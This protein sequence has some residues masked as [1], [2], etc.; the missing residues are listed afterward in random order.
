MQSENTSFTVRALSKK[1]LQ[2]A[3]NVSV[4]TLRSW[5]RTV[6]DLGHYNGKAFTPNQVSII[7]KHLGTP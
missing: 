5:L 4:K 6:P 3:Y 1:E 2:Q 7:I